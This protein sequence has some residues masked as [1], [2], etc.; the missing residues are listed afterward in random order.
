MKKKLFLF[1]FALFPAFNFAGTLYLSDGGEV[2]GIIT[3]LKSRGLTFFQDQTL[4]PYS[5]N[6]AIAY[7][8]QSEPF[9]LPPFPLPL[10]QDTQLVKLLSGIWHEG[11][12]MSLDN[13]EL[14][15]QETD[16]LSFFK[17]SQI[18][19]IVFSPSVQVE[20]SPLTASPD[21]TPANRSPFQLA[22][23]PDFFYFGFGMG[24]TPVFDFLLDSKKSAKKS[25][26]IFHFQFLFSLSSQWILTANLDFTELYYQ[27]PDSYYEDETTSDSYPS[28]TLGLR[29]AY[30]NVTKGFFT[31]FALGQAFLGEEDFN[32]ITRLSV[33]FVLPANAIVDYYSVSAGIFFMY[34]AHSQEEN[35]VSSVEKTGILGATLSLSVL[36]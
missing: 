20:K 8:P 9:T 2:S 27:D 3:E 23:T 26:P 33:G 28:A 31:E 7:S 11:K 36:F 34:F 15:L 35:S 10:S 24:F 30:H 32:F 14:T 1:A 5:Y 18:Q 17:L 13:D 25:G 16:K 21:Q 29:Y 19:L 6:E 4:K 22:E 12:I